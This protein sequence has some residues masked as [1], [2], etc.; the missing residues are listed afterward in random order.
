MKVSTAFVSTNRTV[1]GS[2]RI[3]TDPDLRY[4]PKAAEVEKRPTDSA[5]VNMMIGHV[6][7]RTLPKCMMRGIKLERNF[8]STMIAALLPTVPLKLCDSVASPSGFT[9][10]LSVSAGLG[11]GSDSVYFVSVGVAYRVEYMVMMVV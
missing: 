11:I 7:P 3:C 1:F 8:V 5:L 4:R 2:I 9:F 10:H 6:G